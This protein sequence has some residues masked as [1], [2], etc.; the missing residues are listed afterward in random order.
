MRLLAM[1]TETKS[2][3]RYLPGLGEPTEAPTRTP[4]RERRAPIPAS[5]LVRPFN[6]V[7]T[8]PPRFR[9]ALRGPSHRRED[10]FF[11]LR[12]RVDEEP[13]AFDLAGKAGWRRGGPSAG[14]L[15]DAVIDA[16]KRLLMPSIESDVRG[17][18]KEAS[19]LEAVKVF[20]DNL[21]QLLLAPPL[22]RSV[23]LGIDP[24]QRTG[25]KCVVVDDTGKLLT[26]ALIQLVGG[27]SSLE[28]AK[29]TL[30]DLITKY[31]PFAI[32]VG[33]GT[34]G[35][36]TADFSREV[37]RQ[38]PNDAGKALVVLVSESGASVYSASDVAR[39]EFS[40]LDLTV[41]GA[42]SIARR[43]EDPLAELRKIDPKA[44]GVG[45]YQH[46]VQPTLLRKKLDEVIES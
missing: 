1:V 9:S 16:T 19:D 18:L 37:L 10:R 44:I 17:D 33:N 28:Q 46:D 45:Q 12:S 5:P 31:K 22:G 27:A 40:D 32:A 29:K 13:L 14:E 3:A 4:P 39:E 42:V 20:A 15:K 24:G 7:Q 23:V 41:R 2:V 26:H 6:P 30:A 38:V 11:H 25:C 36:E 21:K 8:L 43:L 34:H 35:R